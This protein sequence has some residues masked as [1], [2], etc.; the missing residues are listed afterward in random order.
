MPKLLLI[1]GTDNSGGAGLVADIETAKTLGAVSTIC[2][3]SVT[4][5]SDKELLNSYAIPSQI[6]EDQ[7]KTIGAESID[8][9]K[10]G[11]LPTLE[12]VQIV[13][14]FIEN[15]SCSNV[16]LDP[17][18]SSSSGGALSDKNAILGIKENLFSLSTVITPNIIEANIFTKTNNSEPIDLD[19][20]SE[21]FF[22]MG[23]NA[24]LLKGGHL[25]IDECEDLLVSADRKQMVFKHERIPGGTDIRG[26]GCRLATAVAYYLASSLKL[27]LAVERGINFVQEYI[28]KRFL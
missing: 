11:M 9:I 25:N 13:A 8:A 14:G 17:V 16:V 26:T 3:T 20:I 5:Q 23:V 1:G 22:S 12:S 4:A 10:I 18:I 19:Q 21:N 27:D 15:C 7:L 28:K 24:L 6:L 2:V